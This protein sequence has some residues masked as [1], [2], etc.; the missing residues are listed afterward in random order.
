MYTALSTER[1]F[2]AAFEEISAF[3]VITDEWL[4]DLFCFDGGA[5]VVPNERKHINGKEAS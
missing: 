5:S 2:F 3:S 4:T 1:F